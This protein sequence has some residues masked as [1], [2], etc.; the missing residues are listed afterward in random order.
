MT[1]LKQFI[2]R[3]LFGRALLIIAIP[4]VVLQVVAGYVFFAHHWETVSRRL[5]G[6][7]AGEIGTIIELRRGVT[8]DDDYLLLLQQSKQR[9]LIETRFEPDIRLRITE[10][11]GPGIFEHTL[12]AALAEHLRR[13][14]RVDTESEPK[15]I[16]VS[17]ELADGVMHFTT[18]RKR[19]F[20]STTYV[21]V[22]WMVGTSLLLFAVAVFFLRKQ[23]RPIRRLAEAAD[24]F[25]KGREADDF[26]PEGASEV[27]QAAAAFQRMRE[28]IRRQISQR[29]DMLA[30]VSH[31]LRTPLTRVKLQLAMLGDGEEVASLR[32]DVAEMEKMIE[33]YLDFARGEGAEA[34]APTDLATLLEEVVAGGRRKGGDI[35]LDSDAAITLAARRNALKRCFTNLVDN[36]LRHGEHVIVAAARNGDTVEIAIDD[37]GP[38]IPEDERG[39]VFRAFYRLDASRNLETGGVG[40]GLTIARDVVRGHG[41]DIVLAE[42]PG[43]GLRALVRLPV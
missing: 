32:S 11:P 5:A 3:T 30:G 20:T 8:S 36:A 41:G 19:L 12:Y 26:K 29:T 15:R 40:L 10:D 39:E 42:A 1:G 38:G 31:D 25:G 13:P 17:V 23:V 2:P 18:L 24:S 7:L 9:L 33:G 21:V 34:S 14:F 35:R 43:G 37:D 27:R 22:F 4:L 28:R 16:T 6:A